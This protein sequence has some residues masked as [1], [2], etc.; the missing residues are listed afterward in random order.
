MKV[1]L[2]QG[3]FSLNDCQ[4][5]NMKKLG[6]RYAEKKDMLNGGRNQSN[7]ATS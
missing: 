7:A 3:E 4:P 6:H 5:Y 2:D 1:K